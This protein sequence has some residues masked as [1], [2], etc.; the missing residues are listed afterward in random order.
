V[1]EDGINGFG[2]ED[3]T[4]MVQAIERLVEIER[5]ACRRSMEQRFSSTVMVREYLR[6]YSNLLGLACGFA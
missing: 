5:A 1:V 6:V 3:V 2:C 4:R